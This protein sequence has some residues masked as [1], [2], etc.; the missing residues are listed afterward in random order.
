[1][2]NEKN[3]EE[4]YQGERPV[5]LPELER[6]TRRQALET[7]KKAMEGGHVTPDQIAAARIVLAS[8]PQTAQ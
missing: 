2:A 5:P 4:E 3:G 6:N 7:I 1:M 8:P